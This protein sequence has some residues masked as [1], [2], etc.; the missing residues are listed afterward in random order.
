[1]PEIE[2]RD[3]FEMVDLDQNNIPPINDISDDQF[4]FASFIQTISE[5]FQ[6]RKL[7]KNLIK[8]SFI[9]KCKFFR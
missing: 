2:A 1:M 9:N 4:F 7:V 8:F 3:Y 5:K 6:K